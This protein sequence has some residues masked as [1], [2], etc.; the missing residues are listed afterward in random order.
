[1]ERSAKCELAVFY[2]T[3]PVLL[4]TARAPILKR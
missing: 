2:A 1:M 4:T 3:T